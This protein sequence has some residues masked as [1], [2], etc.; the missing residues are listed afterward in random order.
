MKRLSILLAA[1]LWCGVAVAQENTATETPTQTD[2]PTQTGTPTKTTTPTDTQTPTATPTHQPAS[3]DCCQCQSSCGAPVGGSCGN[4]DLVLDAACVG[5][6]CATFTPTRTWTS[7]P[8]V[9][10]TPTLTPTPSQTYTRTQTMTITPTQTP[11]ATR[12]FTITKTAGP[13]RRPTN[14]PSRTPT[15]TNTPV[16]TN[17]ATV[18]PTPSFFPLVDQ[19]QVNNGSLLG[20]AYPTPGS[21]GRKVPCQSDYITATC[22]QGG[23]GEMIQL[24]GIP[25]SGFWAGTPIPVNTPFACPGW[26]GT[27]ANFEQCMLC[28]PTPGTTPGAAVSGWIDRRRKA[29][30]LP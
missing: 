7:T 1:I 18:T 16:A 20:V 2:T 5:T 21:C 30:V 23:E 13:T 6:I 25:H 17:T 14:T 12:T 19:S 8:T 29:Q 9:T 26:T 15:I 27:D 4:C 28:V 3:M 11:R 24:Y 10:K 22:V